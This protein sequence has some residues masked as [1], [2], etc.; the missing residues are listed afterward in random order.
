MQFALSLPGVPDP[1]ECWLHPAN[2]DEASVGVFAGRA[3]VWLDGTARTVAYERREELDSALLEIERGVVEQRTRYREHVGSSARV[4]EL[5]RRL[6]TRLGDAL[7][8]DFDVRL[9]YR[10]SHSGAVRATIVDASSRRAVVEV[11][12]SRSRVFVRPGP[13]DHSGGEIDADAVDRGFAAIA[14]G[15]R[16][17]LGTSSLGDLVPARAYRVREAIGGLRVADVVRFVRFDDIDNHYGAYVFVNAEG[18]ELSVPGDFSSPQHHAFYL[19]GRYL[20]PI[21]D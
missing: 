13:L 14:E 15:V 18:A 1:A 2:H 12:A 9:E 3:I 20:E 4:E 16:R 10:P 8:R 21:E 6:A 17:S 19:T 5:A 11:R 7:A